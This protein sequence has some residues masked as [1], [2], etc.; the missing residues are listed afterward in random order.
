M[1]DEIKEK[2]N[3]LQILANGDDTYYGML[4]RL[5]ELEKEYDTAV[6]EL[7]AEKQ[8]AVCEYVSLCESMSRRML[9]IACERMVFE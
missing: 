6:G 4:R 9:E 5:R 3:A 2:M 1:L 8:D 7:T